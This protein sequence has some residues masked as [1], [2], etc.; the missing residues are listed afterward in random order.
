MNEPTFEQL[1]DKVD[2]LKEAAQ[3]KPKSS[4]D[5]ESEI[6]IIKSYQE[7]EASNSGLCSMPNDDLDSLTGF[8]SQAF[9][10][11]DSEEESS[12]SKKVAEDMKSSVPV[13]VVDTLKEL[14]PG[15]LLEA[16]KNNLPQLIKDSIKSSVSE[17]ITEELPK[18]EAQRFVLLQ[19][20][21]SKSLH[22]KIRKSIRMK[23]RKG[24]KEVRDKLSFCTSNV[25]R[26]SQHVQD[27]RIMFKDMASL[28]K[29]AEVL[30]KAN[31][32]GEKCEKNNP[33]SPAKEKDAQHPDQTKGQQDSGAT[34]VAIVQGEQPSA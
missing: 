6:K 17:S 11:H 19:K 15:I 29:A 21:L 24:M 8:D 10:D 33:E 16:L 5:T 7:R 2:N 23:V 31:T 32:E 9:T 20:E 25:D 1:M 12:I 30:K 22:N 18:V 34:T 3:E 14:L 27:L 4:Y 26:N 13:I 28:L